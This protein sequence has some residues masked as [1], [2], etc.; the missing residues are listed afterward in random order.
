MDRYDNLVAEIQNLI[1]SEET[2][3][4]V[5]RLHATGIAAKVSIAIREMFIIRLKGMLE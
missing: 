1:D 3:I 5:L 4:E 2:E